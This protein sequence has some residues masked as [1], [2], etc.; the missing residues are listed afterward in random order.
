MGRYE[1]HILIDVQ[2][3]EN[4]KNVERLGIEFRNMRLKLI[5][6][7]YPEE[8]QQAILYHIQK[9]KEKYINSKQDQD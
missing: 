6:E 8:E 7:H 1:G 5:L 4:A 3:P 9:E 2:D